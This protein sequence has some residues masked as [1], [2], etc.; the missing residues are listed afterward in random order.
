M[1]DGEWYYAK[2]NQQQ[3]PVPLQVM[4]DMARGGQLRPTDLVWRQ[5]MPNWLAAGLVAELQ[6]PQ[7]QP[8]P[9]AGHPYAAMPPSPY[10]PPYAPPGAPMPG[11]PM[12]GAPIP[13][14]Q[15]G[16]YYPGP[17][18]QYPPG[19]VPNYLVQAILV[20]LFCCIPFGIVSIVY[21]AQV[22]EK[23]MRGD[24]AGAVDSSQ[25][26]KTWTLWSFGI[27]LVGIL[28]YFAIMILAAMANH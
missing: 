3:G 13:Y 10:A 24:Y 5:G 14:G 22:N 26:A 2:D 9:A 19:A 23:L 12:P 27:G 28:A 17:Q 25:K 8:L 16:G 18:Q 7:Q 11:A 4:L 20:T 15:P 1:A 6:L 21:A